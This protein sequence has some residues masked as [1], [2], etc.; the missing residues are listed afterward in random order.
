MQATD[1]QTT[2][3]LRNL[4][5]W[6][7]VGLGLLAFFFS[8]TNNYSTE[9][10][11]IVGVAVGA[12][13]CISFA[14]LTVLFHWQVFRC[15]RTVLVATVLVANVLPTAFWAVSFFATREYRFAQ[16]KQ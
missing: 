7:G 14:L 10:V 8:I 1:Y 9:W 11:R 5:G 16:N 2:A 6:T 13:V 4:S 15:Q 12:V 3:R